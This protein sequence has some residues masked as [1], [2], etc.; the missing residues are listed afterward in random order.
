MKCLFL[1]QEHT[2]TPVTAVKWMTHTGEG[3]P[4]SEEMCYQSICSALLVF[5]WQDRALPST[6]TQDLHRAVVTVVGRGFVISPRQGKVMNRDEGS[7][8]AF[9]KELQDL[10]TD[11]GLEAS[12]P[13]RSNLHLGNKN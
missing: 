1:L 4:S 3:L 10:E 5:N 13:C 7:S 8:K 11:P 6:V 9:H 12:L 2:R